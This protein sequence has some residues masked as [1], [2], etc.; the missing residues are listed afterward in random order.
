MPTHASV[1]ESLARFV[2]ED[3]LYLV[4]KTAEDRSKPRV[5]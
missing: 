3:D 4:V 5:L 2:L 1:N